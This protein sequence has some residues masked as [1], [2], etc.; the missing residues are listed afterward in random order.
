MKMQFDSH[1]EA[2][3]A[4]VAAFF[5]NDYPRDI[6]D[7][8]RAGQ[9]LD[10]EDHLRSQR[11]LQSRG[12]LAIGWPVEAGGCGWDPT[13]RYIFEEE[14]DRAGVPN[15]IPMAIIY[16]APV[17]YTFGTAEQKQRWLPDILNSRS[18][19]AQGYSEPEA[20]S[21]LASLSLRADREGDHYV[22]NGTKIWT[23][24]AQ[25]ADWIFCLA[26]TSREP[27]R[28]DGITFLCAEMN[29]PGITV[30]PIIT[31]DGVHHLNRV[32]FEDVRVPVS[33]RIGEEGRGWHYATYLLQNERLS[34]AHVSRK[35]ED[36]RTLRRL[37]AAMPSDDGAMIDDPR[38]SARVAECEVA[39]DVLEIAVLRAL[40]AGETVHP[41]QVSILKILATETAQWITTLFVD[42]AGFNG[43]VF[44]DRSTV[45]WA[46]NSPLVPPFA[47][48]ATAA[49]LFERAQTI[50][51][52]ATEVQKNIVWRLI[53]S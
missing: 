20:G 13:R 30:R 50:Y 16:V 25:W 23:S 12:W 29:S 9:L 28:Q 38:F 10:R 22:L 43:P 33:Q 18:M 26:R 8:L 24:Y 44:A 5:K 36:L 41:A 51:G 37:A 46:M 35:K 2:F 48:P 40:T 21:D 14:Q 7:K 45:D 39:V 15:L 32:D 27:R 3:R 31:L 19:W 53:G 1:E 17:I 4:E 11:A 47:A 49:Y 42:L 6:I 52:G 34:Y